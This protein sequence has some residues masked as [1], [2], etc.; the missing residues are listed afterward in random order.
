MT[1]FPERSGFRLGYGKPRYDGSTKPQVAASKARGNT[2]ASV[3]EI[4][5]GRCADMAALATEY[6]A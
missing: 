2:A 3:N 4:E 1:V 5:D 6:Q